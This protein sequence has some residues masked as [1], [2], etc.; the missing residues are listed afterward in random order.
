[1]KAIITKTVKINIEVDTQE[2]LDFMLNQVQHFERNSMDV[3][4]NVIDSF[5][6]TWD[7]RMVGEPAPESKL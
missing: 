6:I 3:I 4:E 1:M 2:D 5:D 7:A